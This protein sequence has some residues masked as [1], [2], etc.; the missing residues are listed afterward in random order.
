MRSLYPGALRCQAS[1]REHLPSRFRRS[2]RRKPG[3]QR[4]GSKLFHRCHGKRSKALQSV[5]IFTS[6]RAYVSR[7]FVKR[8]TSGNKEITVNKTIYRIMG[9]IVA[10]ALALGGFTKAQATPSQQTSSK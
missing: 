10:F 5:L 8:K 3:K 6:C 1:A 7:K 2:H 4:D 9:I